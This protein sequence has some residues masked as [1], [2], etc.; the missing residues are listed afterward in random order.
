MRILGGGVLSFLVLVLVFQLGCAGVT[1]QSATSAPAATSSSARVESISPASVQVGHAALELTVSGSNFTSQ[2]VI[3]WNGSAKTTKFVSSKELTAQVPA[4]ALATASVVPV[5]VKDTANGQVTNSVPLTVGD[6]PV[7]VTS[8]LP[9]GQAGRS[10]AASVKVTGGVAPFN[11]STDSGSL[12]AGLA[13]DSS[14][15]VISGTASEASETSVG[16]VV[17]DSLNSSA[18]ATLAIQI[19]PAGSTNTVTTSTTYYG[20]GIGTDGLGNTAVGPFGNVV[21]YRIRAKHSGVLQQVLIYLIPDHPGY[22]GGT[23]GS[24]LVTLNK[25]DG[26]AA[27]NPSSTVLASYVLAGAAKLPPPDRYFYTVKFAA[28]PTL[29]AGTI[30]HLV[31]KNVDANPASNF[32][33]VDDMHQSNPSTAIQQAVGS[34]DA[35]VLLSNEDGSWQP[36][37]GYTPIYQFQ[38]S[39]G[40]TEGV[41]YIEGWVDT[42]EPIAGP[43][44]VR[45][46][47]TV[48]GYAR[49]V[50]AVAVRAA[51][52]SG[53]DPLVVR[54]ENANGVLIE[55]TSIP[56]ASIPESSLLAP[57]YF[58]ARVPLASSYTL[59]PGQTYHL[60]LEATATSIY[61]T[62]PIRKGSFYGF[63]PTTF[64]PDGYAE[65]ELLASWHGWT[66]WGAAERIDGDL[67]FY[68]SVVP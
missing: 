59:Q 61:E 25:D 47:F 33:S 41:G 10:Y 24:M 63:Q 4:S 65:F 3:I 46:T 29:T 45:E 38:F 55:E 12:P 26:T 22:A 66:Q 56:A 51:R 58:W 42:P 27:H 1:T 18:K 52:V 35:G 37:L 17:T 5:A 16:V 14:T 54:L 8:A 6:H 28:P 43:L 15:G 7:I 23:G 60:V 48:S 20:S 9:E 21:S 31:F 32:I 68:F 13:M 34:I 53:N 50:N 62:F 11:W 57:S 67:Q 19:A 2:S 49:T 36:R 30:Y 39:N 40:V 44:A 64:F